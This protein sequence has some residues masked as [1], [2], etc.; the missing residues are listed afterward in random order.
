MLLSF[1]WPDGADS[2]FVESSVRDLT[3]QVE[4]LVG[5]ALAFT[6]LNYAA[7]WQDPIGGYGEATVEQ[8]RRVAREYD[9]NGFFQKVV[10]GG[11]KV[12]M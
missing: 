5:D 4:Q 2:T 12:Q 7:S 10:M 6:Y 1:Y 3:I 9:P 8:L 11:F